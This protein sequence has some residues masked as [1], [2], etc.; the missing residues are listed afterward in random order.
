MSL[1][2]PYCAQVACATQVSVWPT[3]FHVLFCPLNMP[4]DMEEE[5]TRDAEYIVSL[6]TY[7]IFLN[8][9]V[10]K[11]KNLCKS[12]VKYIWQESGIKEIH[13]KLR[14]LC[15]QTSV[16]RLGGYFLPVSGAS[17]PQ[18]FV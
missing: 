11:K 1:P 15:S 7:Q 16:A 3:L 9:M 8:Y 4:K 17:S 6:K 12:Q 5:I 14:E 2:A 18:I 13:P 10:L